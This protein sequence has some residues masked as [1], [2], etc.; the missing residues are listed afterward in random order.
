MLVILAASTEPVQDA[1]RVHLLQVFPASQ[2]PR[3]GQQV[4]TS[5]LPD[6]AMLHVVT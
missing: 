1:H 6:V 5:Y 2:G 4:S 3:S